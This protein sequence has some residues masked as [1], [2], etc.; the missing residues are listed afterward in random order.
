MK[1][2]KPGNHLYGIIGVLIGSLISMVIMVVG[3]MR[4]IPSRN[5]VMKMIAD[6]SPYAKDQKAI[7]QSIDNLGES[8]NRLNDEITRLRDSLDQLKAK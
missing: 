8:I 3:P 6:F 7:Q 5:E 1:A 4:E 2:I